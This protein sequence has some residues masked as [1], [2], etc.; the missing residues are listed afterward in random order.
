MSRGKTKFIIIKKDIYDEVIYLNLL[1]IPNCTDKQNSSREEIYISKR[2]KQKY[3]V[4]VYLD[5]RER[6]VFGNKEGL[7]NTQMEKQK[8]SPSLDLDV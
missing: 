2:V 4:N 1:E 3:L 7:R 8:P 5:Q 6:E